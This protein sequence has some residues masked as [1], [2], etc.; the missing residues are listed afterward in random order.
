MYTLQEHKGG[1][2]SLRFATFRMTRR[3]VQGCELAEQLGGFA[4]IGAGGFG[5][6]VEVAEVVGLVIAGDFAVHLDALAV[7]LPHGIAVLVGAFGEPC[8]SAQSRIV[9]GIDDGEPAAGQRYQARRAAPNI[10]GPRRIEVRARVAQGP[11]VPCP[12]GTFLLAADKSG[13]AGA[14]G[15]GREAAIVASG[16]SRPAVSFTSHETPLLQG[17][18]NDEL[19]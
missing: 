19:C 2:S 12:F 8:V 15:V 5:F 18:V 6:I 1:D 17:K 7:L 14:G 16:L 4:V 9:F 13:P 11:Y 3:E 10:G